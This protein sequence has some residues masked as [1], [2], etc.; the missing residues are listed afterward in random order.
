ME[1]HV[2]IDLFEG[3]VVRLRQGRFEEVTVYAED[4]VAEAAKLR[5]RARRLHVV[6]LAG[7]RAGRPV[8]HELVRGILAAFGGGVQVGGGVRSLE[9][10]AAYMRLGA[11]RVVLGTAAVRDPELVR[12]AAEA[13]P[14]R[15]VVAL[16]AKDGM[17]ALS[18]WEEATK[19]PAVD[20]ARALATLPLAAVLYTDVA[21]DG[22]R[23]GPNVE[24]TRALAEA[25]APLEVLASGGVGSLDDVRALARTPGVSGA[26]VGRAIWDGVFTVEEAIAAAD[27]RAAPSA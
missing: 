22:T 27:A 18:G 24:A 3:H 15:V 8:Q 10:L 13:H 5:G 25:A 11:A 16:D 17:V 26:I 6:D 2:A 7:A 14:G 12:A 9:A 23:A 19:T 20:V 1:I 21:R 4:P